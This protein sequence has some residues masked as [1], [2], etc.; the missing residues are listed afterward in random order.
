MGFIL[1]LLS[2]FQLTPDSVKTEEQ[3]MKTY[4]LII[5]AFKNAYAKRTILGDPSDPNVAK[6]VNDVSGSHFC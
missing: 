4:Q 5:E 1:R 2:T 3:A 6:Q